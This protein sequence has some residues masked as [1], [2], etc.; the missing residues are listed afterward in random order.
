M[1]QVDRIPWHS[2]D[3]PARVS[4]RDTLI[5]Q[6]KKATGVKKVPVTLSNQEPT[7]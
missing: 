2:K 1:G 4:H 7:A 5:I 6:G 3:R